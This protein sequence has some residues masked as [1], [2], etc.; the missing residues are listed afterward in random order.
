MAVD[1][2]LNAEQR[3]AVRSL[4]SRCRPCARR[5]NFIYHADGYDIP[6]GWVPL[7]KS[8]YDVMYSESYDWW[9]LAMAFPAAAEEGEALERYEFSDINELGIQVYVG[10][11]RAIVVIHCRLSP[12]VLFDGS[13]QG[14]EDDIDDEEEN[15]ENEVE[16]ETDYLFNLLVKIRRQLMTGDYRVLYAVWET[17][18]EPGDGDE[19][20]EPDD[21]PKPP[22][23][24][25]GAG[26]VAEFA[27][28]LET[29]TKACSTNF[30]L[31]GTCGSS[32]LPSWLPFILSGRVVLRRPWSSPKLY[33]ITLMI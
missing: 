2:P 3:K 31:P 8:C 26:V 1:K 20:E 28:L 9:T 23:R 11:K 18:G 17:Y 33:W 7:M 27:S 14:Y 4:S 30:P 24:K 15:E 25:T 6:G 21:P 19:D 32:G 12:G 16:A 22:D 13:D 29:G 10:E 5:V